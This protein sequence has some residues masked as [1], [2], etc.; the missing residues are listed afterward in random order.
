MQHCCT[1]L[2]ISI[3]LLSI[4]GKL[5]LLPF[6]QALSLRAVRVK[7]NYRKGEDKERIKYS[8]TFIG[9]FLEVYGISVCHVGPK[10]ILDDNGTGIVFEKFIIS[11]LVS[12]NIKV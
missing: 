8:I 1:I 12:L 11:E 5:M 4:L 3:Y 2:G 7:K 9:F 6:N 10:K